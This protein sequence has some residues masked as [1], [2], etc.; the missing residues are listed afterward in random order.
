MSADEE[1]RVLR[2][3]VHGHLVGYLVRFRNGRNFAAWP[4]SLSKLKR[5]LNAFNLKDHESV[6]L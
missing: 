5:R 1:I 4:W 6:P 3:S 2:L